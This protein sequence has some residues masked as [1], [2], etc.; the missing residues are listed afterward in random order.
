MSDIVGK[1]ILVLS[2]SELVINIGSREGVSPS[3][4]FVV[5][6][7]GAEVRDPDSDEPLGQL[8]IVKGRAEAK[9]VQEKMS[10][11]RSSR[12]R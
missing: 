11:I 3:S 1:V 4:I 2:P 12:L 9:H 7:L 8:E 6:A 5:Y 10:T